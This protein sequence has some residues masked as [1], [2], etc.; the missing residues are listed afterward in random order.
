MA[1]VNLQSLE[2]LAGFRDIL[3]SLPATITEEVHEMKT[4]L[5][6]EVESSVSDLEQRR[7]DAS[8]ALHTLESAQWLVIEAQSA[9]AAAE[10]ELLQAQASLSLAMQKNSSGS[11]GPWAQ[12]EVLKATD[13][14]KLAS[15]ELADATTDLESALASVQTAQVAATAAQSAVEF[16]EARVHHR[17]S[18][19]R[20]FLG[21]SEELA[22]RFRSLAR[23]AEV[24]LDERIGS[25][26]TY[27]NLSV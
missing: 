13:A 27:R 23:H 3:A 21:S 8:N 10:D 4:T 16:A 25:A 15:L 2:A 19:Y 14:K 17:Q 20:A 11:E 18:A 6:Q 24:F 12:S 5:L 26:Q 9:V 7:Q 1:E 22:E